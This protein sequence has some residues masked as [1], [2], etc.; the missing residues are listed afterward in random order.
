MHPMQTFLDTVPLC[1]VQA[2]SDI[3]YWKLL[4]R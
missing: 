4:F 1:A 2:L 3:V